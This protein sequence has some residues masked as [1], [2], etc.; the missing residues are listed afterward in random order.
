MGYGFKHGAGG[1]NPL[2]FR[3]LGGSAQ[4]ASPKENDIWVN[5]STNIS[6]WIMSPIDPLEANILSGLPTGDGY[7]TGNTVAGPTAAN[8]ELHTLSY[9][10]VDPKKSYQC[11]ITCS[12][13]NNLWL[14]VM[15]YDANKNTKQRVMPIYVTASESE[16]VYT[17]TKGTVYARVTWRT[18][19]GAT[20]KA[21][22][23]EIPAE[24]TLWLQTS[25]DDG[26]FFNALKK[27]GIYIYPISGSQYISGAW[28]DVPVHSYHGGE[29]VEWISDIYL[30]NAGDQC[31]DVTGG[32]EGTVKDGTL[33]L[34]AYSSDFAYGQTANTKGKINLTNYS[35]LEVTVKDYYRKGA[36]SVRTGTADSTAVA[37]VAI[38]GGNTVFALDVSDITGEHYVYITSDGMQINGGN[39]GFTVSKVLLKK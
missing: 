14:A 1:V 5:T 16:G 6:Q 3:V 9:I 7:L 10:P 21:V 2:N 34:T 36:C 18:F 12:A 11:K 4:P 30:F 39:I 28:V 38:N 26:L 15:E 23:R 13:S 29:W 24:G 19:P 27:N 33:S 31:S 20:T 37:S 22:F 32:W 25:S 17:P 8:P 35:T